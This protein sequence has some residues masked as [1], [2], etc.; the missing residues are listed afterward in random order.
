MSDMAEEASDSVKPWTIR[1]VP[2]EERNAAI[3]AAK[4]SDISIGE[5]LR[6][7][8]R[9]KIQEEHQEPKPPVLV[10]QTAQHVLQM[11][12]DSP[13]ALD[14]AERIAAQIR[15]LKVAGVSVSE[16]AS[17]KVVNSLVSL[18]PKPPSRTKKGP[19]SDIEA[20]AVGQEDAGPV[21]QAHNA[22]ADGRPADAPRPT[23]RPS[24]RRS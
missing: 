19:K 1:G 14:E 9:A 6:W 20:A 5:W 21:G 3:E 13:T 2:P 16:S 22:E 7:A 18:L 12:S 15:D 8:I 10:G 24:R 4:R 11:P 23:A 17:R